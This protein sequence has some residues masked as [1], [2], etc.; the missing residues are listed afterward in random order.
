MVL[1]MMN[2]DF[3]GTEA[4][5][6]ATVKL[7]GAMAA[8]VSC[9]AGDPVLAVES[10]FSV[11]ATLMA[12]LPFKVQ[13]PLLPMTAPLMVI[14][15][16]ASTVAVPLTAP[17][18]VQVT[19]KLLTDSFAEG[20]AVLEVSVPVIFTV[21]EFTVT[22]LLIEAFVIAKDKVEAWPTRTFPPLEENVCVIVGTAMGD[23]TTLVA[24]VLATDSVGATALDMDV[25]GEALV[26]LVN[27]PFNAIDTNAVTT[28]VP[29]LTFATAPVNVITFPLTLTV[30]AVPPLQTTVGVPEMVMTPGPLSVSTSVLIAN[31]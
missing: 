29:L 18:P 24:G 7:L 20:T 19:D 4:E 13:L 15:A 16:F 3:T 21:N 14:T 6:V 25:V 9:A 31:G 30:P 17:V 5:D 1:V 10:D 26:V 8:V 28:H 2:S 23:V 22:A 12:T 11:P 27:V